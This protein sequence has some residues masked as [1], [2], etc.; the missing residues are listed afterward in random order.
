[1]AQ[2]VLPTQSGFFFGSTD[3]DEDYEDD[4]KQ[5]IEIVDKAMADYDRDASIYFYY[6][7]SW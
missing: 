4:L 7:S 5:T 2:D 3:Y 1:V 6:R